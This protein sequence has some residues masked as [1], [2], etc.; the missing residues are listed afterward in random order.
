MQNSRN[1]RMRLLHETKVGGGLCWIAGDHPLTTTP[2]S[3]TP[4][5]PSHLTC[6]ISNGL[7]PSQSMPSTDTDL[8]LS[9]FSVCAGVFG[10]GGGQEYMSPPTPVAPH[11][12][13][14]PPG[15]IGYGMY[16]AQCVHVCVCTCVCG[17]THVCV[18]S[19]EVHGVACVSACSS[20]A[21]LLQHSF[22]ESCQPC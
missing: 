14:R 22:E 5:F 1:R 15:D 9:L 11:I 7:S 3:L 19:L 21:F 18:H 2:D 4:S 8:S 20:L 17:P 16:P 13:G 10:D 6:Y 12:R